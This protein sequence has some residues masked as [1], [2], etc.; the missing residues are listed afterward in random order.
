MPYIYENDPTKIGTNLQTAVA[1]LLSLHKD[2]YEWNLLGIKVIGVKE[3]L[4]I[5]D[6]TYDYG[7][8]YMIGNETDGYE[9]WIYTRADEAHSE[10]YW[11]NVGAFPKPGPQG[12]KG[13][14][15]EQIYRWT[16]GTVSN[17]TYDTTDGAKTTQTTTIDYTD[18]T[19]GSTKQQ[20]FS[21]TTT[22]PIVPGKYVSMDAT[23]DNK[24]MEVKVD[25]TALALDYFKIDKSAQAAPSSPVYLPQTGGT[26][27]I[28]VVSDVISTS[29]ASRDSKGD[30]SF[31]YV[32]IDGI[33]NKNST[34]VISYWNIWRNIY[35]EA[36]TITKT[37]TDTGTL[38][39]SDLE[40]LQAPGYYMVKYDNQLYYRYDPRTAPDGTLNFIHLD[41]IQDGESDYTMTGKC[42]SVTVSTRAWQVVDF[43]FGGQT[44][45]NL[46]IT[47]NVS[48]NGYYFQ[49]ATTQSAAYTTADVRT[50]MAEVKDKIIP[51]VFRKGTDSDKKFY[52]G[53]LQAT[54]AAFSCSYGE[55]NMEFG[56]TPTQVTVRD[57]V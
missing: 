38:T 52:S 16:N 42:F 47:D 55:Q 39:V 32:E 20:Q 11:F 29:I 56:M 19:D 8:A 36:F 4:P 35:D 44:T 40:Q 1:Y 5:P 46:L 12:P 45:H 3:E 21:T 9:M 17:V 18:S 51:C 34:Q 15:L 57:K 22:L 6:G 13:D 53:I 25:D 14:G 28:Y 26:S 23:S 10:A 33:S 54:D 50:I 24:K 31:R 2:Q 30:C 48:G 37:S 49:L 41:S 27:P 43:N 7:D